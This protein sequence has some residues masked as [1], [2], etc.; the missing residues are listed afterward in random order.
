[1]KVPLIMKKSKSNKH[2]TNSLLA[3]AS[4]PWYSVKRGLA[5]LAE[6][7]IKRTTQE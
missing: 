1:M 5:L 3:E 2:F 4:F 6:N 7:F